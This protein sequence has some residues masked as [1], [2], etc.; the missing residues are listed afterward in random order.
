MFG[1]IIGSRT[2]APHKLERC[3]VKAIRNCRIARMQALRIYTWRRRLQFCSFIASLCAR[4]AW[5]LREE[6]AEGVDITTREWKLITESCMRS[7]RKTLQSCGLASTCTKLPGAEMSPEGPISRALRARFREQLKEEWNSK[8][9][10]KS[11][12]QN[13][14]TGPGP[15]PPA[16]NNAWISSTYTFQVLIQ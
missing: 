9:R 1:A 10:E 8:A 5:H 2:S 7:W 4:A 14:C 11:A 3:Y 12:P 16:G 13:C 6:E 15:W